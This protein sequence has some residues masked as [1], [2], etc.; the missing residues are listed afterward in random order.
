MLGRV[1][2]GDIGAT[3]VGLPLRGLLSVDEQDDDGQ[4]GWI[5]RPAH[6]DSQASLLRYE[7]TLPDR[8]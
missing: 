1:I 4:A 3:L 7:R 6:R 8:P 2:I 5:L